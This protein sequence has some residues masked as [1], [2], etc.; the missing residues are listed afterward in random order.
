MIAKENKKVVSI[1]DKNRVKGKTGPKPY[2]P[3]RTAK[4]RRLDD[5]NSPRIDWLRDKRKKEKDPKDPRRISVDDIINE[6]VALYLDVENVP[7]LE[8]VLAEQKNK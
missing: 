7:S 2:K 1:S 5:E 4:L 8:V 3:A 6:A